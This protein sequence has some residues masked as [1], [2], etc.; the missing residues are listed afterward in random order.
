MS[1]KFTPS[2]YHCAMMA[3]IYRISAQRYYLEA[4]N[5]YLNGDYAAA[6]L[7]AYMAQIGCQTSMCF[8]ETV[9]NDK[10]PSPSLTIKGPFSDSKEEADKEIAEAERL[11]ELATD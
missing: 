9:G 11:M 6:S 7:K 1:F 10:M 8:Q 3:E 2:S 5:A 4:Q